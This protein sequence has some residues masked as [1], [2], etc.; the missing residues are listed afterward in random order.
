MTEKIISEFFV[1]GELTPKHD[2]VF[3]VGGERGIQGLKGNTGESAYEI[4]VS[5][6]FVGSQTEWI[7][8]SQ[9]PA[10]FI[11]MS[12]SEVIPSGY[13]L[14]DG[15]MLYIEDYPRLYDSIGTMYGGDGE[16]FFFLPNICGYFPRFWSSGSTIDPDKDT[17]VNRGDGV[18]GDFVG[19]RQW[20]EI[21]SHSH[22]IYSGNIGGGS[23]FIRAAGQ[24]YLTGGTLST[25]GDETRPRNI[26]LAGLIKY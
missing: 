22:K 3:M 6:G 20:N 1:V 2:A 4:A 26:Y 9:I 13:L 14:C 17:R 15:S 7:S 11:F 25:G 12:A 8:L 21:Q 10:G 19:T 24:V 5:N 16:S 18:S 23:S